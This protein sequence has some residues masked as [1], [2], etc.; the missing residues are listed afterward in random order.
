ML[1]RSLTI[2]CLDIE[3]LMPQTLNILIVSLLKWLVLY[4]TFHYIEY[5][6]WNLK[7]EWTQIL[8]FHGM[9]SW[10]HWYSIAQFLVCHAF[11]TSLRSFGIK[12]EQTLCLVKVLARMWKYWSVCESNGP[13]MWKYWFLD[14]SNWKLC[15]ATKLYKVVF[16]GKH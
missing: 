13:L 15:A 6:F 14:V 4:E 2:P 9:K 12:L 16:S 5:F 10:A 11:N 7:R 3:Y 1:A 8:Y